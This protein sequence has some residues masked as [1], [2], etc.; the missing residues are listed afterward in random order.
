MDTL[1]LLCSESGGAGGAC[2]TLQ[3][4]HYHEASVL[5]QSRGG[6]GQVMEY[7]LGLHILKNSSYKKL[8]EA[9]NLSFS[10][11][12]GPHVYYTV[13]LTS[14]IHRGGCEDF[15]HIYDCRTADTKDTSA[16]YA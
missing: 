16:E 7:R 10:S 3:F 11:S 1:S 9:G 14:S 15:C 12:D 5:I 8:M 4:L 2:R 6:G 13:L